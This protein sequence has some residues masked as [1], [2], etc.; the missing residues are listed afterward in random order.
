MGGEDA[1]VEDE[2]AI[3][4]GS[5]RR[6]RDDDGRGRGGDRRVSSGRRQKSRLII[7]EVMSQQ[8]DD[9]QQEATL[10]GRGPLRTTWVTGAA[11]H[12]EA[13]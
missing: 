7:D 4:R 6:G 12:G 3:P 13:E 1:G 10:G 8:H 11:E 2:L 9:R 5:M